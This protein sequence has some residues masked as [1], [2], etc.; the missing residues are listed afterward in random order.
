MNVRKVAEVGIL[1]LEDKNQ[2]SIYS[3]KKLTRLKSKGFLH[4]IKASFRNVT[5]NL[6][7]CN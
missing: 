5:L 7:K 6:S 2:L 1:E 3:L 4:A